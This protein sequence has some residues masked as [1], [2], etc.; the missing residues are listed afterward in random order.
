M[1]AVLIGLDNFLGAGRHVLG[2]LQ[3]EH[4]HVLGA[5]ARCGAGHIDGHVAATHHDG[6]TAHRLGLAAVVLLLRHTAQEVNSNEHALGV[7]ARNAGQAA[8]L[9]ANRHIKSLESLLTQLIEGDVA[10]HLDTQTDVDAH[11]ADDIDLGFDHVVL[12]LI[13]GD[14]VGEHAAGARVLL[15][16]DRLVA[17]LCQ[18]ER[19]GKARGT[20]ADHRDLFVE[21]PSARGRQHLGYVAMLGC[22]VLLGEPPARV[23]VTTSG[24]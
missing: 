21:A 11:L 17:L 12:E 9:A 24:T 19:A 5:Q 22:E 7:L 14:A 1:H 8:A 13:A 15:E 23:G 20:G 2:A 16:D 4:L 6:A 3:A 10:T 18:V